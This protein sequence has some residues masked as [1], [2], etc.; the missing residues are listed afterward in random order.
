MPLIQTT[1]YSCPIANWSATGATNRVA[2]LK[3]A[4]SSI[5]DISHLWIADLVF[6][7]LRIL[8]IDCAVRFDVFRLVDESLRRNKN[9]DLLLS[10]VLVQRVFTPYHILESVAL[11]EKDS[12]YITVLLTPLKQFFDGDVGYDEGLFL[13]KRLIQRLKRA[14]S[15]FLVV[16][17]SKYCHPSF[18]V[19]FPQLESISSMVWEVDKVAKLK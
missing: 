14:K 18:D 12:C 5:I 2:L 13:L 6:Q 1:S 10:S 11:A 15:I 3:G 16:E 19:I 4:S 9:P 7:N 8:V 17:K